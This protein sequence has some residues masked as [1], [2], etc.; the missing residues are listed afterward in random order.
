MNLEEGGSPLTGGGGHSK[1][2]ELLLEDVWDDFVG[3]RILLHVPG[4]PR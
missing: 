3:Y 2:G 1:L 4:W